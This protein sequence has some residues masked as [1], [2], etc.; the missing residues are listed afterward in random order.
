MLFWATVCAIFNIL[1]DALLI[2]R[3]GA[4]GAGIGSGTAQMLSLAGYWVVARRQ[5]QTRLDFGS[6]SKIA[7]SALAMAPVAIVCN[8]LLLPIVAL[9]FDVIGGILVFVLMLRI[10]RVLQ[11]LDVARLGYVR[12]MLPHPMRVPVRFVLEFVS[13]VTAETI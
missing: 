6:M 2:P 13:G 1:V 5:F 3:F 4:I 8:A 10:M 7:V 12:E 11:P 9:M